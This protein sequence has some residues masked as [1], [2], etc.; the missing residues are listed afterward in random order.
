MDSDFEEA[1]EYRERCCLYRKNLVQ[2]SLAKYPSKQ[3]L[4]DGKWLC[5]RSA[6]EKHTTICEE[7][8]IKQ[9]DILSIWKEGGYQYR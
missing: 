1:E 7:L 9:E 2:S 3:I 6:Q 5:I 8:D 4:K